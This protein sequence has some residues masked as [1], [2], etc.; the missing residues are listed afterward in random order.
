MLKLIKVDTFSDKMWLTRA[1]KE[2]SNCSNNNRRRFG[3]EIIN[4]CQDYTNFSCLSLMTKTRLLE[5]NNR[6]FQS[7]LVD[8][9]NFWKL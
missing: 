8:G 3:N 2:N 9:I 1:E 4:Q 7:A 5:I 6:L